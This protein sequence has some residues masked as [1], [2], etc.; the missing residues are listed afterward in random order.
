M[1]IAFC[2]PS[3]SGKSTLLKEVKKFTVFS[4]KEVLIRREDDFITIRVLKRIFGNKPF[5]DYKRVKFFEKK[6]P[7]HLKIFSLFVHF[8]YPLFV[9]IEFLWEYLYYE[10]LCKE[11]VLMRDRYIYDYL[12]TFKDILKI[13]SRPMDIFYQTF[14]KPSLL[15]FV[16]I[17]K[18]TAMKR[19]KNNVLG[20]ITAKELFHIDVLQSYAKLAKAKNIVSIDNTGPLE[21]SINKVKFHIEAQSAL[22]KIRSIAISGLDGAGKTT[23]ASSICNYASQLHVQCKVIH[24]YHDNILFKL[25]KAL[26]FFRESNNS[27]PKEF[28]KRKK[29]L[30]W[31]L[32][33]WADSYMQYLFTM[34]FY[35]RN[36]IIFDRYFYDYLV[37]FNYLGIRGIPFFK[38]TIPFVD[39]SVLLTCKP[40][41]AFTRKPEN[42]LDFFV[43]GSKTYS[44]L[45]K[46]Y[47]M[48]IIDTSSNTNHVVFEELMSSIVQNELQNS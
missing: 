32:L 38:K 10:V 39:Y 45:A 48:K 40:K 1:I 29:T 42:T 24:F 31:A 46:E 3:S 17:N 26:G 41:V 2:G 7:L 28:I 9:Y 15:F 23:L 18:E 27:K 16:S 6:V 20:K 4:D 8:F 36:L 44:K 43:L 25:L 12:V 19:N 37:T 33:T 47:R 22:S 5:S 13:Y 21:E 30:P 34:L 11:K 14:P 35:R